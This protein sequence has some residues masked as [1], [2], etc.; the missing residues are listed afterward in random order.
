VE[1]VVLK[2]LSEALSGPF[3]SRKVIDTIEK[4]RTAKANPLLTDRKKLQGKLDALQERQ[5]NLL[6]AYECGDVDGAAFRQE[7]VALQTAKEEMQ[8]TL[9]AAMPETPADAAMS[10][11]MIRQAFRDLHKV[12]KLASDVEKKKLL[13][14]LVA[15]VTLDEKRHVSCMDL[16][17]PW[18]PA[19]NGLEATIPLN[20]AEI[21]NSN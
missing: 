3:W 12:L 21:S 19:E 2:W 6:L 5:R 14:S 10:P 1:A 7:A 4:R 9:D 8:R 17:F 16:R 13:H 18:S 11:G 20:M 15:K